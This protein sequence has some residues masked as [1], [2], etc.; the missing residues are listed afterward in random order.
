MLGCSFDTFREI[1]FEKPEP[2][3]LAMVWNNVVPD[4]SRPAPN[5]LDL[6]RVSTIVRAVIVFNHWHGIVAVQPTTQIH[7]R[8]AVR[9][10]RVKFYVRWL[11]ADRAGSPWL[12]GDRLNHQNRATGAKAHTL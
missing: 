3:R 10:K 7:L 12:E 4:I 11:F 2:I 5:W 1:G 6:R 8:T 9:A